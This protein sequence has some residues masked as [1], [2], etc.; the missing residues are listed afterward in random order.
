M[1]RPAFGCCNTRKLVE[2]HNSFVAFTKKKD[3]RNYF[4]GHLQNQL[5]CPCAIKAGQLEIFLLEWLSFGIAEEGAD[6]L[7]NLDIES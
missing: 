1:F 7:L 2:I 4:Q 3:L 6:Y 5:R